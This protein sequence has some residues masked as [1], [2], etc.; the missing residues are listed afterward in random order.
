MGSWKS[1]L[2]RQCE[3]LIGERERK[4]IKKKKGKMEAVKK[5]PLFLPCLHGF[6]VGKKKKNKSGRMSRL[7]K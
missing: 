2:L 6:E 7:C 4:T 5:S 1:K 3:Q